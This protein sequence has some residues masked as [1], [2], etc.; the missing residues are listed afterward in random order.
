MLSQS[1]KQSLNVR[2]LSLVAGKPHQGLPV[3]DLQ[4]VSR[5]CCK[6][7]LLSSLVDLLTCVGEIPRLSERSPR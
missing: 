6:P 1:Q 4:R 3:Y 2:V 5:Y 7:S